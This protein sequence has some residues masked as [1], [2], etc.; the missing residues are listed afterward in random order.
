MRKETAG[1]FGRRR[2][3][4]ENSA[5]TLIEL[6][7]VIAIIA[8]LAAMLLPAL[9]RSKREAVRINCVTN[10][11]QLTLAAHLYAGDNRDYLP[12]NIPDSDLGWVGGDVQPATPA[13]D[14]TNYMILQKSVLYPYIPNMMSFQCPGDQFAVTGIDIKPAPIRC[15]T[16][17]ASGMMGDNSTT[18]QDDR[19][20]SSA[21]SSV[22]D[23]L[24]EN[25]KLAS[26]A[27]PGPG[28]ASYFWDEQ[29]AANPAQTSIDD[30]YFAIDYASIEP[31]GDWRNIPASR[32]G[33]FG[34]MSFADGHAANMKWLEPKTQFM[35]VTGSG[36]NYYTSGLA[37]DLDLEQVWNSMYPN[38]KWHS[39]AGGE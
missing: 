39:V 28:A 27:N 2:R 37:N 13:S 18:F 10:L 15:R 11:K 1:R 36:D 8:I 26:V 16:Y 21:A 5:F 25:L 12:P 3:S 30:G 23:G 31:S 29:D 24:E 9:A 6:L 4:L 17:S 7:V 34:Q 22:H 19:L 14:V 32:H 33:N 38:N 20:S 35:V